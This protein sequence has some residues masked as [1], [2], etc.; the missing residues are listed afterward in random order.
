MSDELKTAIAKVTA[1]NIVRNEVEID[2]PTGVRTF[3]FALRPIL[4]R[5][6]RPIAILSEAMELSERKEAEEK[7]R[8]LQKMEAIGQLTG[9]IAHDFNNMLAIIIG[10][11][12]LYRRRSAR[13]DADVDKYLQSALDGA[14]KAASLTRR[15]LAFSRQ[16]PLSPRFIQL[17]ALIADLSELLR[18]TLGE[19]HRTR[20]RFGCRTME[21]P[22]GCRRA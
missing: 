9:G 19:D 10:S 22:C 7:V 21:N 14:E 5:S 3:D 17:N 15:L 13:G 6:G 4:D 11:I 1:G 8:Q 12:N 20:N 18:R 16:Q 2:L